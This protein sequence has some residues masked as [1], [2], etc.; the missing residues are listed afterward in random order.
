[1]VGAIFAV[2]LVV[3]QRQAMQYSGDEPHYLIV[4]ESLMYD[5]DVDVKNQYDFPS[6]GVV[7]G[8]TER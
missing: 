5:G 7:S 4:T 2:L 1:M 6:P 8:S 3:R